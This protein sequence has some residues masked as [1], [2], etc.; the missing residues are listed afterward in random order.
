MGIGKEIKR[1][2]E[3][4]HLTAE[5]LA[6]GAGID[7][8]RL[9]KWEQKDMK[10]RLEDALKL[11]KYFGISLD[12]LNII[13]KVPESSIGSNFNIM[14][15]LYDELLYRKSIESQSDFADKLGKTKGYI[16]QLINGKEPLPEVMKEKIHEVFGISMSYLE[17]GAG[18]MFV[19][20][21]GEQYQVKEGKKRE[22]IAL[23]KHTPLRLKPEQYADA[24]GDWKGLPM[25]NVEV[26]AS[27][28][29][30]YRDEHVFQPQYYLHD[31]RF[32]DCDFGAIVT[33]DSMH[34]EIRHGDW[35]MCKEITDRRF[36]VFGDIYYVV[37]SNGLETCKYI[38]ADPH[39][40]NN[41]LLVPR[42]EK[43]SPSP[44]PKD[45]II[46]LFRVRGILRGY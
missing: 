36:I 32:K 9:R 42:N 7:V 14:Q 13:Q 39:E 43:I 15:R 44:I 27:F 21:P 10:P 22:V 33:G 31:P 1:I 12:K 18:D 37:A 45:M 30:S 26:T 6:S 25:Y 19:E 28:V 46:R 34:S 20:E 29:E 38:N 11:E 40:A 17:T 8:G 5:Q 23:G 3:N 24:F 16:S 2:R 41:L 4:S 35:I